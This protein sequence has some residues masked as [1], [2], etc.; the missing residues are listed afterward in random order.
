MVTRGYVVVIAYYGTEDVL[1]LEQIA[2]LCADVGITLF[3]ILS[4]LS[5]KFEFL[6]HFYPNVD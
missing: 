2:L 4:L 5:S 6:F 1:H 3:R